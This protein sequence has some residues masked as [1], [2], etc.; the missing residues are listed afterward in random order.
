MQKP[1]KVLASQKKTPFPYWNGWE[2]EQRDGS[3]TSLLA[4][5]EESALGGIPVPHPPFFPSD[6]RQALG[7][8]ELVGDGRRS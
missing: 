3:Q 2:G 7:C 6:M 4:I 5:G 8:L 1:A